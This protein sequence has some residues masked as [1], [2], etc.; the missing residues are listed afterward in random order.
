MK[1]RP[2]MCTAYCPETSCVRRILK[3]PLPL[4]EGRGEGPYRH[5]EK[6]LTLALSQGEREQESYHAYSFL[7]CWSHSHSLYRDGHHPPACGAR[8]VVL[9]RVVAVCGRGVLC[10][11]GAVCGGSG[12][13]HLCRGDCGAVCLCRHD[14][15]PGGNCRGT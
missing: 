10:A 2:W 11:R 13:H 8:A 3:P 7:H 14:A 12:S 5:W 4:G 6:P 9:H 15:Q 1:C